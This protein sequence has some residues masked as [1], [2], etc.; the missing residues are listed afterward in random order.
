M[1]SLRDRQIREVLDEDLNIN[2]RVNAITR[3]KVKLSDETVTP[4]KTRDTEIEISVDKLIEA[5]NK[6]LETKITALEYLLSR[7]TRSDGD[8]GDS[9]GRR[10]FNSITNNGDFITSYN[11]LIRLY[12]QPSLSQVSRDF[13]K[14]KF[15]ELKSNIDSIL[16]GLSEAIQYLFSEGQGNKDVLQLIKSQA[17]YEYVN[18]ALYQ[19]S[20]Y[21]AIE[22][23]DIIT[24]VSRV[25][26]G[27]SEVQREV[28]EPLYKSKNLREV[29]LLK[30]PIEI[31]QDKARLEALED[32]IGFKFPDNLRGTLGEKDYETIESEYGQLQ[33][34]ITAIDREQLDTWISDI[35]TEDASLQK[36]EKFLLR[37]LQTLGAEERGLISLALSGREEN[38]DSDF[39]D[40]K[41]DL[42]S[43]YG[44]EIDGIRKQIEDVQTELYNVQE[45]RGSIDERIAKMQQEYEANV[46][47]RQGKFLKEIGKIKP[48]IA[49]PYAIYRPRKISEDEIRR[50]IRGKTPAEA[51]DILRPIN[52]A[53]GGDFKGIQV[54]EFGV[55]KLIKSILKAQAELEKKEEEN[56]LGL[57]EGKM[58]PLLLSIRLQG[59]IQKLKE[60]LAEEYDEEDVSDQE[61]ID[62][63]AGNVEISDESRDLLEGLMEDVKFT[64]LDIETI[65]NFTKGFISEKQKELLPNLEQL[66]GI[67][68]SEEAVYYADPDFNLADIEPEV[69]EF[70]ELGRGRPIR[71]KRKTLIARRNTDFSDSRN[72][73]FKIIDSKK[74]TKA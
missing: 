2:R 38:K 70:S 3:E 12:S 32:E 26:S 14:T 67:D 47:N 64:D 71:R 17:V 27:L 31:G 24:S 73:I 56:P 57:K 35:R 9:E 16:Y 54:S 29:S 39:E 44:L 20:L 55:N 28:L 45:R 42:E 25:L 36:T 15:Q 4:R 58:K 65:K 62:L 13:I 43:P 52:L 6:I 40:E 53:Y 60:A 19:G 66:E 51:I 18:S 63:V 69:E 68:L 11:Q 22:Q 37:K 7:I 72:D 1:Q 30:L 48:K 34:D 61:V 23:G 33:G 8:I 49:A 46:R 5:L 50:N 41:I 74:F 21:K 10:A 59:K